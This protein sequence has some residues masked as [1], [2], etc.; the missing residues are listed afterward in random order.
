MGCLGLRTE[1]GTRRR[2]DL[3]VAQALQDLVARRTHKPVQIAL[4]DEPVESLDEK[5]VEGVVEFMTQVAR[6]RDSV[7]VIT[8]L[9][10]LQGRMP[11]EIKV[12]KEGGFSRIES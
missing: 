1:P 3:P 12:I 5:G 7:F 8:H 10:T 6:E 4:Y 2:I 11:Q 9:T